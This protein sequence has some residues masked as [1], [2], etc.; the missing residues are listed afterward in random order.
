MNAATP[1][2]EPDPLA[3]QGDQLVFDWLAADPVGT[4]LVECLARGDTLELCTDGTWIVY[5]GPP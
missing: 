2:E 4:W 3:W 1:P 5:P